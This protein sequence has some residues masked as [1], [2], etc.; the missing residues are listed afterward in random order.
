M[1]Q[2]DPLDMC[3]QP[4]TS[5]RNNGETYIDTSKPRR[6]IWMR[7]LN[8]P[9]QKQEQPT[10]VHTSPKSQEN[11]SSTKTSTSY[12]KGTSYNQWFSTGAERLCS[13]T[14]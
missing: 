6:F 8:K 4:W 14:L 3:R 10:I 13:Y 12:I 1:V 5:L 7:R 9:T 11:T 2:Q